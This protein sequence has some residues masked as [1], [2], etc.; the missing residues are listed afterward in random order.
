M[1]LDLMVLSLAHAFALYLRRLLTYK[2]EKSS[3][4]NHWRLMRSLDKEFY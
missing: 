3:I 1:V 4:S 2:K